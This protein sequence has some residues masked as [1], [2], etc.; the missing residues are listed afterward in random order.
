MEDKYKPKKCSYI[1]AFGNQ[2]IIPTIIAKNLKFK[3]NQLDI[4]EILEKLKINEE[5]NIFIWT[6]FFEYVNAKILTNLNYVYLNYLAAHPSKNKKNK[7]INTK[8]LNMSKNPNNNNI[9]NS[10]IEEKN[11][12]NTGNNGNNKNNNPEENLNNDN[13]TTNNIY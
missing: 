8:K 7:N 9:I 5:K 6:E 12:K 4:I 1:Q 10:S 11:L 13:I 3:G 2:Y